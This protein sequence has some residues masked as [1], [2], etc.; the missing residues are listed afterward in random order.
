MSK[1]T[2]TVEDLKAIRDEIRVKV[3]LGEMAAR[4]WWEEVEPKLIELERSIVD[5]ASRAT[6]TADM[7]LEEFLGAFRR[8]RDRLDEPT[9]PRQ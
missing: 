4:D 7:L 8:I 6:S 2:V 3:H 5:G 9:V 1:E